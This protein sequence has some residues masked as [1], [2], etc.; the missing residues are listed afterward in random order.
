MLLVQPIRDE[1]HRLR[2]PGRPSDDGIQN[3][4]QEIFSNQN[5]TGMGYA[6]VSNRWKI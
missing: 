2:L 5:N 4:L 1:A 6:A 3:L